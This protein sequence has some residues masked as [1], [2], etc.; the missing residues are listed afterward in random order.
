MSTF[1]DVLDAAQGLSADEQEALLEILRR[2]LAERR[3]TQLVREVR[4]ARAEFA[5]GQARPGTIDEIMDEA[6]VD[7]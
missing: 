1:S 3:R 2:R 4:E 7:A 6:N 5:A